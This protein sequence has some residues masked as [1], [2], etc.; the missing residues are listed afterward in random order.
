MNARFENW[1]KTVM[2][3]CYGVI[4]TLISFYMVNWSLRVY[5][6]VSTYS[7]E[8]P[9]RL[10][11]CNLIMGSKPIYMQDTNCQH[12]NIAKHQVFQTSVIDCI[13]NDQR[14]KLYSMII[15]TCVDALSTVLLCDIVMTSFPIQSMIVCAYTE[16]SPIESWFASIFYKLIRD[17]M[18]RNRR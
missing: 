2:L 8:H 3:I 16:P 5:S 10:W 4:C 14:C 15:I 17:P 1:M 11:R 12:R 7:Y 18:Y 13:C 6:I 9:P